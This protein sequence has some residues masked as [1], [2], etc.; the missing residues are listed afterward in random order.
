LVLDVM[1]D[2]YGIGLHTGE[3]VREADDFY[4]RSEI[5]AARIAAEARGSEILGSSLVRDLTGSTASSTS[6]RPRIR[7]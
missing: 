6:R 5:P 4:G 3:P 1:R 7:S 2:R